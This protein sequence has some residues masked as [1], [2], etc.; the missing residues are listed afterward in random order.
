MGNPQPSY[1]SKNQ[2]GRRK[3]RQTGVNFQALQSVYAATIAGDV[4]Q[5]AIL[6][7]KN[8]L[9]NISPPR[10]VWN[11][12]A[13]PREFILEPHPMPNQEIY[14]PTQ[15]WSY[16]TEAEIRGGMDGKIFMVILFLEN[17]RLMS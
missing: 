13:C 10:G 15:S 8:Q 5:A 12:T 17:F 6:N 2:W 16:L 14:N 9:P 1:G 4:G 3:K 11:D 7:A